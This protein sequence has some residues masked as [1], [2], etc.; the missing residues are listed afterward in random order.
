MNLVIDR[1]N[2]L[3]KLGVFHNQNLVIKEEAGENDV[4]KK[5]DTLLSAYTFQN[6]LIAATAHVEKIVTFLNNQGLSVKLLDHKMPMPFTNR[7]KTPE[8]LGLDRMALTAAAVRNFPGRTVLIID[9]GTCITYD[10]KTHQ[11]EYLGGAISPGLAMRFKALNTFTE[12]LPLTNAEISPDLI[13]RNTLE[14]MQSGVVNG[15]IAEIEGIIKRY[16]EDYP[17]LE[18]IFTG[19]DAQFL[20]KSLKNGIFANLNFLL[21]GLDYIIEFNKTQ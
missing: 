7:Y 15:I 19:G 5:L 3:I 6:I 17:E 13:G 12:K 20:S 1:G 21:E 4:F 14:C 8:T 18:I 11:E 10:L 2:T 16:N 9:A